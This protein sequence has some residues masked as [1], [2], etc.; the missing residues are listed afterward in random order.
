MSHNYKVVPFIGRSRGS[1]SASDVSQ[2][3]EAAINQHASGGWEF[4]QL[5]DVNIEV[6]PGCLGGLLGAK[7]EYVRFD[8]LIFRSESTRGSVYAPAPPE[9]AKIPEVGRSDASD[10]GQA[11]TVT[12]GSSRYQPKRLYGGKIECWQ[13]GAANDP[14]Q[15][16]CSRC[17]TE[18]YKRP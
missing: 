12:A 9:R 16:R 15:I 7:V 18:L 8:Q 2:Q 13:C 10:S 3:L 17:E 4:V 5:A 14:R 11:P 1:L 6:Q